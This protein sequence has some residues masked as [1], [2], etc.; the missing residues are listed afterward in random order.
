MGTTLSDAATLG[1]DFDANYIGSPTVVYPQGPYALPAMTPGSPT[2]VW[3][4]LATPYL[5][6]GGNLLVEFQVFGNDLGNAAFPY[7]LDQASFVSPVVAGT[8]GCPHS[9]GQIAH[10]TSGP[11]A[12]GS[13]WYPSL[14]NALASTP[15]VL[16]VAPKQQMPAPLSL[17][18]LGLGPTCIG[19]VPPVFVTVAGVTNGG[20]ASWPVPVPNDLSFNNVYM[21]SQVVLLDGLAP[22]G[23][24]VSNASEIRFGVHPRTSALRSQVSATAATGMVM[25]DFGAVTLFN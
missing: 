16:F 12:I 7:F 8:P 2:N 10:L 17:Q 19:Q 20:Y 3:V 6:P 5:Y 1:T 25:L 24:L 13:T 15:V 11:T 4:N 23:L 22:G 14:M 18:L 21:T 9:G